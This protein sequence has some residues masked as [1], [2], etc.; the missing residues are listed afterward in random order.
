MNYIHRNN[1]RLSKSFRRSIDIKRDDI[2]F[3]L[4]TICKENGFNIFKTM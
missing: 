2:L 3:N 4:K 1:E